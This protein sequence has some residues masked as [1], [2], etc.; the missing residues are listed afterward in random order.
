MSRCVRVLVPLGLALLVPTLLART[1][2]QH[3][4]PVN[5]PSPAARI[6]MLISR[7]G[8]DVFHE[9]E[10]AMRELG[11]IGVPAL[12]ALR[13]AT[14]SDDAEVRA[15]SRRLV[16]IIE[17]SP[18]ALAQDYRSL[19]LS[20]PPASASL[21]RLEYRWS[22]N[23]PPSYHLEF[24]LKP[25]SKSAQSQF[26]NGVGSIEWFGR[27]RITPINPSRLTRKE[28]KALA[29]SCTFSESLDDLAR[30]CHHEAQ[31]DALALAIDC[32][33]RG[34]DL[35]AE[36]L[37]AKAVRM[38]PGSSPRTILRR[39]A[40]RYWKNRLRIPETR[41]GD[42]LP[43]LETLLAQEKA[44]D[45]EENRDLLKSLR[46]ALVPSKARPGT[47]A[48][49]I[50][51]LIPCQSTNLGYWDHPTDPRYL[52]LVDKGF[53]AVPDLIEH[54]D[55]RR[56]TRYQWEPEIF[57]GPVP[58]LRQHRVGDMARELLSGLSGENW[59]EDV[60]RDKVRKWWAKAKTLGEER[61]LLAQVL[62]SGDSAREPN[63]H[64][65][66][67]LMKKYP[68]HLER[69]YRSLLSD[70]PNL[71]GDVLVQAIRAS[72]LPRRKQIA[73][74][75]RAARCPH[76]E[77][78][79]DA[80]VQLSKLDPKRFVLLLTQ[81]LND[82]P[83]TPR[84]DYPFCPEVACAS[85]VLLTEDQGA[86]EAVAKAARRADARL[87][88]EILKTVGGD[89]RQPHLMRQLTFLAGFLNDATL[90]DLSAH[91][92]RIEHLSAGSDYPR[93]EVRNF[94]AMDL[95]AL[96]N[97]KAEPKPTWTPTQWSRFREQ[98]RQA[99]RLG[100]RPRIRPGEPFGSPGL[101]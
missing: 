61:Y 53:E 62:P 6:K 2:P 100:A 80:L 39:G 5:S 59:I 11:K 30:H 15:R 73:L 31:E 84:K 27:P 35:L 25:S 60:S 88:L 10:A 64:V 1:E 23:V 70:H 65:L 26:W 86:W 50:D 101:P 44:L 78:R 94:A 48:A 21:V 24:L 36:V 77:H 90:R 82:M 20:L 74:Y 29:D 76:R 71:D 17:N 4:G 92:Q 91:P 42:I 22:A 97:M 3:A 66:R 13:V 43:R 32:Q 51:E 33:V 34:W 16:R 85:L 14:R 52:K 19:G 63:R 99:L 89:E 69:V 56:L 58:I 8:S 49:L 83:A 79:P 18:G 98:V 95:A 12:A 81:T 37:L 93:L 41:W 75:V 55:D 38:A 87:R 7:L 57:F 9:R 68:Q 28:T 54:L 46:A 96:L 45:T 47:I 67:V 72:S 40:W